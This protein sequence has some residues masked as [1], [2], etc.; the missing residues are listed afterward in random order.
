MHKEPQLIRGTPTTHKGSSL[1]AGG[2]PF[3]IKILIPS[4]YKISSNPFISSG[5]DDGGAM[6]HP[7]WQVGV[8]FIKILLPGQCKISS[9]PFI[10]SGGVF[11]N[12]NTLQPL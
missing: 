6:L 12:L 9:D 2:G 4:Q 11:T 7:L 5:K 10:S 1:M 3:F 8:L